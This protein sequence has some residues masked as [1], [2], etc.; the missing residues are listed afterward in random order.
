MLANANV[1]PLGLLAFPHAIPAAAHAR[2]SVRGAVHALCATL[3]LGPAL[4]P[5]FGRVRGGRS[6]L[7]RPASCAE[8]VGA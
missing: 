2:Q 6:R 4:A 1:H 5:A 8:A 3:R 7:P